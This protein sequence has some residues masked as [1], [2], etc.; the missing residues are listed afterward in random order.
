[1]RGPRENHNPTPKEFSTP[2]TSFAGG[3]AIH[4]ADEDRRAKINGGAAT[5]RAS[6]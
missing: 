4:R 2:E 1:M 6:E 5:P 3:P